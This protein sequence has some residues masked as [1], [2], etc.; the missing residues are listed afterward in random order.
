MD[1]YIIYKTFVF[2]R[3]YD[4]VLNRGLTGM[5]HRKIC[6]EMLIKDINIQPLGLNET[7][8]PC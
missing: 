6:F 4:A 7:L 5:L 8:R 1:V 3:K 2:T